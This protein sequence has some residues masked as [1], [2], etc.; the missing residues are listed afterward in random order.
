MYDYI[1][2]LYP[3]ERAWI[4]HY[5]VGDTAYFIS[6]KGDV[7]TMPVD[8]LITMCVTGKTLYMV[9]FLFQKSF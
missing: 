5:N 3:R 4:N 7:D 8:M 6:P 2:H 9:I 1:T